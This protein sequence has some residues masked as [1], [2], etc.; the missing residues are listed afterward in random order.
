[1]KQPVTKEKCS[2]TEG[3]GR[4]E[5]K[6]DC[7]PGV[8]FS[9]LESNARPA[10]T[11]K[12]PTKRSDEISRDISGELCRIINKRFYSAP[13][14][15]VGSDRTTPCCTNRTD[16]RTDS[17]SPTVGPNAPVPRF[18]AIIDRQYWNRFF[19]RIEIIHIQHRNILNSLEDFSG[20][21]NH[22]LGLVIL[23]RY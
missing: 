1:M 4:E 21:H 17:H 22:H 12:E 19:R 5:N 8:L 18:Q 6:C 20:H 10:S 7:G 11:T 15:P 16:R 23:P 9:R 14:K 2:F 3:H 13:T